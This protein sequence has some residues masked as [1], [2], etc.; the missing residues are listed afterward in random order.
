M[1]GSRSDVRSS[2]AERFASNAPPDGGESGGL[3]DDP[4]VD[5]ADQPVLLRHRQEAAGQ[6]DFAVA[7]D[8]PQEQLLAP[9][10]PR[11]GTMGWE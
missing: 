6:D 7:P 8:H 9:W 3:G 4:A 11:S 5:L 2:A 1:N 10:P